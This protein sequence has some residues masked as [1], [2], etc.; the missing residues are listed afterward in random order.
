MPFR[1]SNINSQS[2][3]WQLTHDSTALMDSSSS[4]SALLA[5][6]FLVL[7]WAYS[8][9]IMK[10]S[11]QYAAPFD[12][13]AIR[14]LGG[15]AVL[16][17]VLIARRESLRPPP[18]GLTIAIGLCQTAGMQGLAQWALVSGGAGHVSLLIYTMPFWVVL[19]AWQLLHEPPS[20]RQWRGIAFAAIGL[21]LILEPW[22]GLG[23][24]HSAALAILGGAAWALGTVLSKRMF[25]IHAPSPIGFTTWQMLFGGL[26][27]GLVAVVAPSSPIQWTPEFIYELLYSVVLAS[28]L[29]WILWLF[30]VRN[31]PTAVAGLSS[32]AVPVT[33]V[34]MAW[35]LL[36]ERP[37]G[38]EAAGIV[39]IVLGLL[40]VSGTGRYLARR[41]RKD[42]KP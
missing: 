16:F 26:A 35:V 40:T 9:V 19:L 4:R 7:I 3:L 25:Q 31:L 38:A 27:L 5:L 33:V 20:P 24:L 18:L 6:A 39:M 10:Q 34:L 42:A 14:Y 28:S 30:V 22:Q 13:V 1:Q 36:H 41:L 23:S 8:W 32:M 11:L 21:F 29:A 15:A 12:F 37:D 2:S 17:A